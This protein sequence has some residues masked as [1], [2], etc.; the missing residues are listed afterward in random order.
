LYDHAAAE[1]PGGVQVPV[2]IV[3]HFLYAH[4]LKKAFALETAGGT[5]ARMTK[6]MVSTEETMSVLNKRRIH[7]P[8]QRITNVESESG[9]S[10][11][12]LAL[13]ITAACPELVAGC[14]YYHSQRQPSSD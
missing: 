12:E 4:I 8:N 10:A 3:H 5:R 2:D 7:N 11:E 6:M 1:R 9:S 13:N 14:V